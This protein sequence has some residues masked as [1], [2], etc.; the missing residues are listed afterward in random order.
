MG[1]KTK[2]TLNDIEQACERIRRLGENPTGNRIRAILGQGS[3]TTI[4]QLLRQ[5]LA[6]KTKQEVKVDTLEIPPAALDYF[7]E[8]VRIFGQHKD[9]EVTQLKGLL[10]KERHQILEILKES[11]ERI[12]DLRI[13]KMAFKGAEDKYKELNAVNKKIVQDNE[14]MKNA[15]EQLIAEQA[16]NKVIMRQVGKLEKKIKALEIENRKLLLER[17]IRARGQKKS[18]HP[19]QKRIRIDS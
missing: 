9:E 7:K 19:P 5:H 16:T 12:E 14:Q 1:R 10:K 18:S 11:E 15:H 4:H 13:E 17:V 2:L 3:M 8:A 6:K